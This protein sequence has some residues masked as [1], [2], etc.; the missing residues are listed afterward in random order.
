VEGTRGRVMK[1]K[2]LDFK[3]MDKMEEFFSDIFEAEYNFIFGI[4]EV[5]DSLRYLV[6]KN[7][8]FDK[9]F[10]EDLMRSARM[11]KEEKVIVLKV[12][13]NLWLKMAKDIMKEEEK[14]N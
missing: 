11:V 8:P 10:M 13:E 3:V 2:V 7:N 4:E 9:A 5:I 12:Y 14:D 1:I 6:L